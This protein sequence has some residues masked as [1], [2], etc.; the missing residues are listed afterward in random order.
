M[1]IK[2]RDALRL[3]SIALIAAWGLLSVCP[4]ADAKKV[5]TTI[6]TVTVEEDDYGPL[7]DSYGFIFGDSDSR[8]LKSS[9]LY[10]LVNYDSGMGLKTMLGYARNEIFARRGHKFTTAKYKNFYSQYSWYKSMK[11]KDVPYE[12]LNKYEK[13][14]V[15]LIKSI[16]KKLK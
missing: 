9:E 10:D 4:A 1:G 8:Y 3:I 5:T 12:Q 14:N 2:R 15:D 11:K 13:K 7:F 16:E 6:T